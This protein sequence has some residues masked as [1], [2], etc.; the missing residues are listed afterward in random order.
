MKSDRILA[1]VEALKEEL[2]RQNNTLNFIIHGLRQDN[3]DLLNRLMAGSMQ[4]YSQTSP[5]SVAE[6]NDI[7]AQR[8]ARDDE[9]AR[10][11]LA[12]EISDET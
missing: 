5:A 7:P 9:F 4:V 1:A 8:L 12:G 2:M 10:E 11:H 3:R 6:M